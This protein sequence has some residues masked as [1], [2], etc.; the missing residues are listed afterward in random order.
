MDYEKNCQNFIENYQKMGCNLSYEAHLIQIHLGKFPKNCSD[1]S[2]EMGERFH[3]DIKQM[4]KA[5][6]RRFEKAILADYCWFL[7]CEAILDSPKT[8]QKFFPLNTN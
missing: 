2:D 5:Y 1:Y 7:K 8:S 6:Q 4:E 3:Q